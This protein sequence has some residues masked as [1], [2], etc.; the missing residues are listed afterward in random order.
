M[1][2]RFASQLPPEL[3]RRLFGTT[4][5]LPNLAPNWNV[6]ASQ[7]AMVIRRHPDT[8]ERRLGALRWGLVPRYAK[9][10]EACKRPINARSET[11]GK[12]SL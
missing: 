12:S 4:G 11:A 2:G 9:D 1:C 7:S 3:V 5:D 6:A 8:G 10:L